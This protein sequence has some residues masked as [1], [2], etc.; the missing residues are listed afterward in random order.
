MFMCEA[1]TVLCLM[2]MTL[3]VS[4]ESLRWTHTHTHIHTRTHARTHA[5]A[6]TH[7]HTHT[8]TNTHTHTHTH[9]TREGEEGES[10]ANVCTQTSIF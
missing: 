7:T 9:P 3:I 1:V 5:R 4:E 10:V 6:H 2:M 8:H